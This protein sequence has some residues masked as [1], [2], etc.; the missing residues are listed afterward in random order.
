MFIPAGTF[1]SHSRVVRHV[2]HYITSDEIQLFLTQIF[3]FLSNYST[4][5]VFSSA[6]D[7]TTPVVKPISSAIVMMIPAR[8]RCESDTR[9]GPTKSSSNPDHSY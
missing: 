1:I 9:A 4:W 7:S 5:T 8:S 3:K 2:D 6:I